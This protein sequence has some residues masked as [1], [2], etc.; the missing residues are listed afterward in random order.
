MVVVIVPSSS[1][2][3][4]FMFLKREYGTIVVTILPIINSSA[5]A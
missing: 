5:I 4:Y 2:P 3:I 1:S